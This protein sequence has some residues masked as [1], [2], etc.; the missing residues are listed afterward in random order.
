MH[1]KLPKGLVIRIFPRTSTMD[2]PK[3]SNTDISQSIYLFRLLYFI[4]A[5]T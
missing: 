5:D 4:I 1:E 2:I 3:T